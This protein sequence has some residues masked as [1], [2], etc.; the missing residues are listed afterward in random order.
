MFH[1]P[2]SVGRLAKKRSWIILGVAALGTV[3]LFF[4]PFL[5]CPGSTIEFPPIRS[6]RAR[7]RHLILKCPECRGTGSVSLLNQWNLRGRTKFPQDKTILAG[8]YAKASSEELRLFDQLRSTPRREDQDH[9]LELVLLGLSTVEL[10]AI[11]IRETG[12]AEATRWVVAYSDNSIETE[13]AIHSALA[14]MGIPD[15]TGY[16]SLGEAGW[17]VP[18]ANFLKARHVLIEDPG[19]QALGVAV[20]SPQFSIAH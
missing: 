14:K 4:L 12:P 19:C 17:A 3:A 9:A 10:R 5:D 8:F 1:W 11:G 13:E 15:C 6:D 20:V 18:K 16:L 7:K 2:A